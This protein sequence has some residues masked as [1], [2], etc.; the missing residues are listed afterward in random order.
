[1][2][3]MVE[4]KLSVK[5]DYSH[6]LVCLD[7]A[8]VSVMFNHKSDFSYCIIWDGFYKFTHTHA[9]TH[10]HTHTHTHTHTQTH[11][12]YAQIFMCYIILAIIHNEL[13]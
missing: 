7:S 4:K 10:A 9:R 6:V 5:A 8:R 12:Q 1:M 13:S 11:T 2:F 3:A